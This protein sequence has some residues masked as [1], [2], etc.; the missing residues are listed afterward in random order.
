MTETRTPTDVDALA[1]AYLDR[2]AALNPIDAT[3]IGVAGHD[4]RLPDYTPE[5]WQSVSDN[6]RQTLA[7]LDTA[8]STD[9][10]DRIT[11]AA[12][13]EELT[14]REE[15]RAAGDEESELSVIFSPL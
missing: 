13:R 2:Y 11:V 1:D 10:T 5:W 14:V 7:A 9:R 4:D 3:F 6:R 12:L 15:L 8:Q